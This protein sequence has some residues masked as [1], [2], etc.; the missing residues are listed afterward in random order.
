[1]DTISLLR[2]LRFIDSFFPS[3]GF[4]FSSGLEAAV[5]GGAVRDAGELSRYATGYLRGGIGPCDAVA[6]GIVHRAAV[7]GLLASA[8]EA[9]RELDAMKTSRESR[10]ASR[11][12]GRQVIRLAADRPV[13]PAIIR[14]YWAA[15]EAGRSPG[16]LAASLGLT[17][18]VFGWSREEAIAAFLYHSA[19]GLVSAAIKLLPIGQREAQRLLEEWLPTIETLSREAESRRGLM[20]WAPVQS[21]YQMRHSRLTTRL[22]RS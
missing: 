16:H 7:S 3:G 12:M 15:V 5:Q 4:A 18:A 11:Q 17:L 19:T 6:V 9:D 2:G 21:I 1:M 13:G 14:D 20:S 10:E 22:F 8:I